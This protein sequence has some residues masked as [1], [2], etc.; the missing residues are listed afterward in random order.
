MLGLESFAALYAALVSSGGGVPPLPVGGGGGL[1]PPYAPLPGT[2][3]FP[4]TGPEVLRSIGAPFLQPYGPALGQRGA[5]SSFDEGVGQGPPG[6]TLAAF[7]PPH[8]AASASPEA[9]PPPSPPPDGATPTGLS[10]AS[11]EFRPTR[12]FPSPAFGPAALD[13]GLGMP[14]RM[15][16]QG[17]SLGGP[18]ALPPPPFGPS[19]TLYSF[20]GGERGQG[21]YG[22]GGLAGAAGSGGGRAGPSGPLGPFP[23]TSASADSAA[24]DREDADLLKSVM[25]ALM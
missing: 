12:P 7:L 21:Y 15:H 5:Y 13:G 23:S 20:P 2:P 22:S 19:S 3:T 24:A 25:M 10:F 16:L 8:T 4:F 9:V 6:L 11:S 1:Y 18:P 17:L 14:L